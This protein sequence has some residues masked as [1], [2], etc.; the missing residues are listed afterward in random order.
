MLFEI[1][2]NATIILRNWR[3]PI[4]SWVE[5]E[6]QIAADEPALKSSRVTH[7]PKYFYPTR[8]QGPLSILL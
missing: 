2:V 8:E 4:E 3:G 7:P 6:A 1:L 5:S